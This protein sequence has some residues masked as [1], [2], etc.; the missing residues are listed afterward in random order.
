MLSS[1]TPELSPYDQIV[2]AALIEDE[3][4]IEQVLLDVTIDVETTGVFPTPISK[5]AAE[6]KDQAVTFLQTKYNASSRGIIH[7]YGYVKNANAAKI[8]LDKPSSYEEYFDLLLAYI[9]GLACGNHSETIETI[10]ATLSASERKR[11]AQYIVCGF[12]LGEHFT[13]ANDWL[14]NNNYLDDLSLSLTA[15]ITGLVRGGLHLLAEA[16]LKSKYKELTT[17]LMELSRDVWDSQFSLMGAYFSTPPNGAVEDSQRAS[18]DY[19]TYQNQLIYCLGRIGLV[20]VALAKIAS[21]SSGM[22][23]DEFNELDGW[24]V[25]G[26]GRGG[27][28]SK[29]LTFIKAKTSSYDKDTL[30]GKLLS[31]MA[32]S[33]SIEHV[34]PLFE[35]INFRQRLTPILLDV[36]EACGRG[37][38]LTQAQEVIPAEWK[39]TISVMHT[40][41]NTL[42][43]NRSKA[44][45]ERTTLAFITEYLAFQPNGQIPKHLNSFITPTTRKLA[46]IRQQHELNY[47]QSLAWQ[48]LPIFLQVTRTSK[49]TLEMIILIFQFIAPLTTAE[50]SSASMKS[51]IHL[52]PDRLFNTLTAN[53]IFTP[54]INSWQQAQETLPIR[55]KSRM[56]FFKVLEQQNLIPAAS[57]ILKC[58]PLPMLKNK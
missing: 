28:L 24:L 56:S 33:G 15:K 7:G 53:P 31:G 8:L 22:T 10:L 55:K 11:A 47:A 2:K 13:V 9:T 25:G 20:D 5:L 19:V 4:S 52:Q 39:N 42:Q 48:H 41:I 17:K 21:Y 45:Y 36:I 32:R 30:I 50:R 57:T 3:K 49:L 14:N 23:R 16:L 18:F 37:G 54:V 58:E 51:Y 35:M 46:A 29:A 27:H 43:G 38:F 12:I 44:I 26:L 6:G 1:A 34:K 40:F